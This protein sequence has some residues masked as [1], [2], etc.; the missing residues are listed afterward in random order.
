MCIDDIIKY[1]ENAISH[2][3]K[4]VIIDV[5]DLDKLIFHIKQMESQLKE[6]DNLPSSLG[7]FIDKKG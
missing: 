7:S 2:K 1:T 5:K 4:R 6:I 3:V